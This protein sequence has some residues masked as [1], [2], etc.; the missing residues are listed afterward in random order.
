MCFEVSDLQI[1]F[2]LSCLRW[3]FAA[4]LALTGDD[5]NLRTLRSDEPLAVDLTMALKQGEVE[6]LT[7]L[8]ATDPGLSTCVVENSKGCTCTPIGRTQ[9]EPEAILRTLAAAGAE[10]D[11]TAVGTWQRRCIGRRA[12]TTWR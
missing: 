4:S 11:A 7:R 3:A 9:S 8:L 1:G 2:P 10:L 6:R 5:R 12:T